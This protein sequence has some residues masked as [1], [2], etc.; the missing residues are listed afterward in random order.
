[1]SQ[2]LP[3]Y[4]FINLYIEV[5][6]LFHGA[7]SISNGLG[8]CDTLLNKELCVQIYLQLVILLIIIIIQFK[9]RRQ[10]HDDDD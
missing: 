2:I 4:L 6:Y 10:N 5:F 8:F 1:M 3:I 7:T 9:K